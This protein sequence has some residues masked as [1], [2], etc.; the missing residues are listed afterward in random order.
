MNSTL[1]NLLIILGLLTIGYGA[2]YLYSTRTSTTP[3]DRLS[4]TELQMM[5]TRT[6]AFIERRRELDQMEMDVNFLA[7]PR[8]RSLESN[9]E[10]LTEVTPGRE[11]PF[12]PVNDN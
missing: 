3:S 2:Y 9:T 1:R 10:P 8:F 4:D 7:D 6:Q 12:A 5:L 11:N